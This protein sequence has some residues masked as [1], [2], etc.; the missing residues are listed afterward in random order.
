MKV[1]L[2]GQDFLTSPIEVRDL[3]YVVVL[4]DFDQPLAV[5][6]EMMNQEVK[7]IA[8]YD[9]RDQNFSDIIK[10]I[11]IMKSMPQVEIAKVENKR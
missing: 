1:M 3:K 4:D 5:L 6:L 2:K 11:G 9:I 8:A 7:S 10:Q